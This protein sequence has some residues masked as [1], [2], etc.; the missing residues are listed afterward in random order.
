MTTL[1]ASYDNYGC[2]G[3]CDA[4]CYNADGPH[5]DC[6]CGGMNHGVGKAKAMKNT[7]LYTEI[8]IDEWQKAHPETEHFTV[9]ALKP[10]QLDM[11]DEVAS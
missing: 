10:V 1:I 2:T 4:K 9:P 6:I 7:Q 5:C 11:F 3:R 8:W